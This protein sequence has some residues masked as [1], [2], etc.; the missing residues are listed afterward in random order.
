M[1]AVL[2]RRRSR[3]GEMGEFSPPTPF[4]EAPSFFFFSCPSNIEIIFDFSD[5]PD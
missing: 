2:S 3:G 4:Y 1:A 5:F